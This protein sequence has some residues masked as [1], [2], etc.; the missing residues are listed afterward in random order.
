MAPAAG[1]QGEVTIHTVC[2]GVAQSPD[3][4]IPA[5]SPAGSYSQTYHGIPAGAVCTVTETA[6][7]HT[8]A[9]AVTVTGSGQEVTVPAGGTATAKLSDDYEDVSGS[10]VVNKTITGP[11]AGHQGEVRIQTVCDGTTLSPDLVIPANSDAG[12]YS[13]EYTGLAPG[14]SCT[15]TEISDGH[16][17]MVTVTVIGSGQTVSVPPKGAATADLSDTYDFVPGSLTVTKTIAGAA[18]GKQGEVAILASCGEPAMD[19]VP[20]SSRPAPRPAR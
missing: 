3:L 4:V 11:A 9:V 12:T 2:D 15:V 5:N 7:G 17:S 20:S 6:D 13:H 14:S 1:T 16:T 10:L 8:S 18:A 19:F